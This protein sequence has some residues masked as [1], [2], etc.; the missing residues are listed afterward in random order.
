MKKATKRTSKKQSQPAVSFEDVIDSIPEPIPV[1]HQLGSSDDEDQESWVDG[2]ESKQEE[3]PVV[4]E[5]KEQAKEPEVAQKPAT[6]PLIAKES[7]VA[8]I[9]SLSLS[10]ERLLKVVRFIYKRAKKRVGYNPEDIALA[11][12]WVD[13]AERE[14]AKVRRSKPNEEAEGKGHQPAV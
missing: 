9:E 14:L 5:T 1:F 2:M 4:E 10:I 13:E 11:T 7:E 8:T 6:E 12:R 3:A